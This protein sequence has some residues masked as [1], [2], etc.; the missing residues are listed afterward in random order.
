MLDLNLC[1][2]ERSEVILIGEVGG[3]DGVTGEDVL[4]T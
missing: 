2:G 1:G 3:E 4:A